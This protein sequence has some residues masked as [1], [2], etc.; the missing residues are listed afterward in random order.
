M[1]ALS[2]IYISH[3]LETWRF[4][5]TVIETYM[6]RWSWPSSKN[7]SINGHS[8]KR[9]TLLFLLSLLRSPSAKVSEWVELFSFWSR[10][11]FILWVPERHCQKN[12]NT[13][14]AILSFP[15]YSFHKSCAVSDRYTFGPILSQFVFVIQAPFSLY[16][17]IFLK[18]SNWCS[19]E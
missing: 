15:R 4:S 18:I 11:L 6:K 19:R 10:T 5:Q 17:I 2:D 13:S 7:V 12:A 3:S 14:D 8:Y 9:H 16:L 1:L